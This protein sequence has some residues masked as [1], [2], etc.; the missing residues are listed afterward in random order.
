MVVTFGAEQVMP[1][2]IALDNIWF[3]EN[4]ALFCGKIEKAISEYKRFKEIGD[5]IDKLKKNETRGL[6]T[7]TSKKIAEK[8]LEADS[9][10]L[11]LQ[12]ELATAELHHPQCELRFYGLDIE[13]I[14]RMKEHPIVQ[15]VGKTAMT[16]ASIRVVIY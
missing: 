5:E 7:K 11:H 15:D 1:S 4:E 13:A 8:E 14:Q 6:D 12:S 16:A 3:F 2:E 10:R 9:I